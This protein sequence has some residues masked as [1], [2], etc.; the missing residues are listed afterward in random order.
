MINVQ[1]RSDFGVWG[2]CALR[3]KP[4]Y[5]MVHGWAII[6]CLGMSSNTFQGEYIYKAYG[7]VWVTITYD[8]GSFMSLEVKAPNIL[9]VMQK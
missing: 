8:C 1:T 6:Y 7:H 5:L 3:K 9:Q 4:Q 2:K